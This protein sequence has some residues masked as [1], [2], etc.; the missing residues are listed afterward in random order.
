[1]KSLRIASGLCALALAFG[2]SSNP[3]TPPP[4][5]DTGTPTDVVDASAPP[6][7]PADV[8]TPDARPAD[9]PGD[10]LTTPVRVQILQLSDWH[11]Q[12]DPLS[13]S[14]MV[15]TA[16]GGS[17]TQDIGGAAALSAYFRRDRMMN[18]NTLTLSAGDE[19][20]ASPPLASFFDEEPAVVALNLMG[21]QVSTFG[22]HNFD[23]GI[24]HLQSMIGMARYRYVSS[25]LDNLAANLMNVSAPF[26]IERVGGVNV[27]VVGITNPDAPM[28][29]APGRMGTLSVREP[30]AAAMNAAA[31]A[32]AAGADVVI[33]ICHLGAT[34]VDA[35]RMPTGPLLDFARQLNGFT[36][37]LGD[38]TDVLV[39]TEI[40]GAA[41]VENRS[42]GLTYARIQFTF[43]PAT[44]T[45][46]DR[47]VEVVSPWVM[48]VTPDPAVTMALTT[49]RDRLSAQL[50]MVVAT[51]SGE[52]ARG[53][54]VERLG[55][56][57]LGDLVT[58]AMRMRYGTQ[59]A[60]T[61]G[62]GLRAPLPSSYM[63]ANRMLRRN[64][65]GYAAG[66][67]YD[68]VA[69]DIYAVLPFGNVVVTRT[70]T[71]TQLWAIMERS[72]GML[73]A[74]Y[75][76]FLQISGFRVAYD[77]SMPTGMRVRRLTLDSGAAIARDN[78]TYTL[79][80]NDFTNS[81]GDG[82][83]ELADGMGSSREVMAAVVLDYVRTRATLMPTPGM[84][85]TTCSGACP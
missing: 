58:D 16:D 20:G 50:D 85:I 49:Y 30:A 37:V 27:G 51:T 9:A 65:M 33:A 35:N 63:P 11:G 42:K 8:L 22:N 19:F 76:G 25:N 18:P 44:R 45:V 10:V 26:R 62:G 6:D 70:V 7:V 40:N 32:R 48:D 12:I 31:M 5:A 78:T 74:A 66:P 55:E 54:N 2:C 21:L 80:T 81:G 36:A 53:S 79:A 23:R 38:H 14:R 82:H 34:G 72:V 84:R 24:T 39:N 52:F 68:L 69:G 57:P 77:P 46:T 64:A 71:G 1:M 28:L 43:N 29:T 17:M 4:P 3:A 61:N 56:V 41:V 75:G 13:A 59:L 15:A 47:A 60:V 83:V 67:P 73:P